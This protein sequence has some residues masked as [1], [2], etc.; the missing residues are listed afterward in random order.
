MY[1]SRFLV[2]LVVSISS[3]SAVYAQDAKKTADNFASKWVT[4]YNAEMLP[5]LLACS[6]RM[7]SSMSPQEKYLGSR[8][9]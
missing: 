7:A 3:L 6:P 2:P 1:L 9:D 4:T 8:C 5:L